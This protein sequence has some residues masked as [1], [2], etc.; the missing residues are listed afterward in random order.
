MNEKWD[1]I[2]LLNDPLGGPFKSY[3][4]FFFVTATIE[5]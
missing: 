1:D 2:I 5:K 4:T 3:K